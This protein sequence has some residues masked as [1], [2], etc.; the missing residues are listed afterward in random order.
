MPVLSTLLR[1]SR[2]DLFCYLPM[3]WHYTT[4]HHCSCIPSHCL[5]SDYRAHVVLITQLMSL[6]LHCLCRWHYFAP[7]ACYRAMSWHLIDHA[8]PQPKLKVTTD[9][10][11]DMTLHSLCR[12]HHIGDVVTTLPMSC[13]R[14]SSCSD[15]RGHVATPQGT[16]SSLRSSTAPNYRV[17][18]VVRPLALLPH[19][20]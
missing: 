16:V 5:R 20:R 17:R 14:H 9:H 13:P 12:A 2:R 1:Q 7:V 10:D 8:A 6:A 19:S 3:A 4:S 15:H 18:S 11:Q